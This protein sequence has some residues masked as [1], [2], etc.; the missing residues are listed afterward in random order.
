MIEE[1]VN[2]DIKKTQT[3]KQTSVKSPEEAEEAVNNMERLLEVTNVTYYGLPTN[4]DKYLKNSKWMK[5]LSIWL[6]DLGLVNPSY[7]S[8]YQL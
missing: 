8:K 6:K 4:K 2:E 3:N 5:R 1:I 7:C